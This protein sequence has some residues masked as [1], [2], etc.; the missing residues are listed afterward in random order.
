MHSALIRVAKIMAVLGALVLSFL[1]LMT[2]ISVLGR[3][4]NALLNS[5]FAQ[6]HAPELSKALLD[7]GVKPVLGDFELLENMMPF[8]IFAFL[9]LAQ[10]TSSHA[11]VDVFT[12]RLPAT[13]LVWMRVVIEIVFAI[14]LITFAYKLYEGMQ[15]KM[16]YGETTYLIQ[17]PVWWAYA[18]ALVA[19]V[20]AALVGVAMAGL[21]LTQAITGRAL[22]LDAADSP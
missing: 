18:T 3:E 8:T 11:T 6:T 13:A 17:F 19:A 10:V 2:C 12:A 1:I 21:L 5:S 14:V 20:V 4:L 9:P 22:T 7:A 15:A 16:R